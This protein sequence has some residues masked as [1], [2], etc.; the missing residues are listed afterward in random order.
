MTEGQLALDGMPEPIPLPHREPDLEDVDEQWVH[1]LLDDPDAAADDLLRAFAATAIAPRLRD[2]ALLHPR[3]ANL[4]LAPVLA[5]WPQSR[6]DR[7]VSVT[8]SRTVLTQWAASPVPY[9]RAVVAMNPRCPAD[10]ARA[11][12][13]DLDPRVRVNAA[14]CP[15]LERATRAAMAN[16][17]PDPG[18]RDFAHWLITTTAGRDFVAG[19]RYAQ[20]PGHAQGVAVRVITYGIERTEQPPA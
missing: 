14:C 16:R 19:H 6:K 5:D 12:A 1:G 18:V 10:L 4:D 2:A 7:A 20:A 11:L 8:D 17:D 3:L 9:D 15:Q 13:D